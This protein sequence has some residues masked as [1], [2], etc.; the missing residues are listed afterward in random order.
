MEFDPRSS[1]S[2]GGSGVGGDEGRLREGDG[3]SSENGVGGSGGPE[4]G[5]ICGHLKHSIFFKEE[6]EEEYIPLWS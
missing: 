4:I 2:C 5:L 3:S 6:E 1:S